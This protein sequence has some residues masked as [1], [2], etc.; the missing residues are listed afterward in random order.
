MGMPRRVVTYP[1][2]MQPLNVW[3]SISAFCIGISM[4]IFLWNA[5]QSMVFVRE[6]AVANPW[7]SRSPEWQTPTPVP[8]YDF[9][10]LPRFDADPYPYGVSS[11][12]EPAV[13]S[14]D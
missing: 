4:L 8:V 9:A 7:N 11:T 13:A 2:F 5:V 1:T 6:R 3:V 14:G 12:G 10:V